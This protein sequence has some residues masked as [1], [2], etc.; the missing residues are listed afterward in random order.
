[1]PRRTMR[2]F[3][4]MIFVLPAMLACRQSSTAA[5]SSGA[6]GPG[7]AATA[8]ADDAIR[9]VSPADGATVP[10]RP[11][12]EVKAPVSA[13]AVWVIIHP[14]E[15]ADYWVQPRPSNRGSGQWR[16]QVY[17][18]QPGTRDEGKHFEIQAVADPDQQ[19]REGMKLPDW[20]KARFQS[21]VIE[22][23]RGK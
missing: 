16:V 7:S 20:P 10:M 11:I 15:V 5:A 8:G 4:L 19:L 21:P 13:T 22:V 14:M 9:I 6:P 17:V 3:F 1:M 12:V 23:V 2:A 18:G